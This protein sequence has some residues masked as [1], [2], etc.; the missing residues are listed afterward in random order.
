M[1]RRRPRREHGHDKFGKRGRH[2]K[3]TSLEARRW[4]DEFLIPERPPWMPAATYQRL[5]DLRRGL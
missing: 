2:K 1:S 5:A 4:E 3:A